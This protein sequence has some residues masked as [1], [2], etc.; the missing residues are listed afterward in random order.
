MAYTIQFIGVNDKKDKEHD[1][2]YVESCARA[3]Y[4]INKKI[5]AFYKKEPTFQIKLFYSR[6]LYDL[7]MKAKTEKWHHAAA[8]K[9][10]IAIFA[11]SVYEKETSYK[12][13]IYKATIVHEMSHVF[14]RQS[15]GAFTPRWLLEGLAMNI[16]G[17]DYIRE[18]GWRGK[19][20]PNHLYFTKYGETNQDVN[21]FYRSSYLITKL[22]I[23]KIGLKGV[24]GLLVKYARSPIKR[25]YKKVFGE[26]LVGDI[27][28]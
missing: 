6:K 18:R 13:R 17:R 8:N 15:V 12:L 7:E 5:F 11:P 24:T 21:E 10:R 19:P 16:E 25:N 23:K 27:K 9:H 4:K 20:K 14:Y 26:F 2:Q 1:K 3:A 22:I 28:G